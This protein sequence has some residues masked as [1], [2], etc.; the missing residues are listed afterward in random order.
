MSDY[1]SNPLE[2]RVVELQDQSIKV[3]SGSQ[4]VRD[5][6]HHAHPNDTFLTLCG[7]PIHNSVAF[8]V[9]DIREQPV[10][11][12]RCKDVVSFARHCSGPYDEPEGVGGREWGMD[13]T[14]GS[15]NTIVDN[16]TNRLGNSTRITPIALCGGHSIGDWG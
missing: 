7:Y 16:C 11:C 8:A 3:E 1:A 12:P 9:F 10:T 14:G 6:Y 5:V 15:A 2:G 4:A 13:R